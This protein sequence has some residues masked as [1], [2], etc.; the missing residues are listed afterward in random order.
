MKRQSVTIPGGP[1]PGLTGSEPLWASGVTPTIVRNSVDLPPARYPTY[2]EIA[3]FLETEKRE[4]PGQIIF[5]YFRKIAEDLVS[6]NIPAADLN[7]EQKGALYFLAGFMEAKGE[8]LQSIR[9][10]AIADNGHGGYIIGI[11]PDQ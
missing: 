9:P 2:A 1:G 5:T 6:K 7:D 3:D 10:V 8:R 4:S 11:S